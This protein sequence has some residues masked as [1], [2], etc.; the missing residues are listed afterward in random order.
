[1]DQKLDSLE[2]KVLVELVKLVQKRGMQGTVG[3]WKDFLNLYDKKFGSSLS[4]P[5]RR[6]NDVLSSFLK[7][8]G[9]EE[10]LKFLAKALQCHLNRDLVEKS[11]KIIS[12]DESPEQCRGWSAQLLNTHNTHYVIYSHHTKRLEWVVT[13]LGKKSKVMR[14]NTMY[15]VDCEMV[16][17]EDGSEALVKVCVVDRK[18]EVIINELVNPQKAVAD[19]RSE[20]TGV[21]ADDL[22]GVTRS[23]ADIQKRMKKLLSHGAIL[24]GHSLNNDLQALKLDHARVIDTSLVFKHSDGLRRPSLN[25]LC[26]AILGYEIRKQGSPHNCVDDACAAMKLALAVIERGVDCVVREDVPETERAKLLLHRIPTSV[27]SEELHRVVPGDFTIEVKPSKKAEGGNYCVI[28]IFNNPQE[29]DQAFEIVNGN[30][31]TDSCGRPQKLVEFQSNA[32]ITTSLYVRK[33]ALDEPLDQVSMK[34]KRV[35]QGEENSGESKKLKTEQEIKEE[36]MVD[37]NQSNCDDHLKEIERL[38]QEVRE[39]DFQIS[40]QDKIISELRKKVKNTKKDK[41]KT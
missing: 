22:V 2:K 5:A 18:L 3:G 27:P 38:R 12:V 31:E 36:I 40:K 23:L 17:C 41:K 15:A 8:F 32:G 21:S 29:A 35:F 19:Y 9:K 4:D 11:K 7:T 37:S 33:M 20:I 26:K 13:N 16:L 6:S 30:Q 28:A 10:D 24:V 39:K 14:S 1:M 34:K 25:N